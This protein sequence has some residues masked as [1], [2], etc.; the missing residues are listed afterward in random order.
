MVVRGAAAQRR[1]AAERRA[2]FRDR[3]RLL[4]QAEADRAARERAERERDAAAEAER[5]RVSAEA[6]PGPP[7]TERPPGP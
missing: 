1:L 2:A 6:S 7:S 4:R 3:D 5:A